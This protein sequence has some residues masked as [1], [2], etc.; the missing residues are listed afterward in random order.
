MNEK[1]DV[2]QQ[3][4]PAAQKARII[5]GCSTDRAASRKEGVTAS[6]CSA[7]VMAHLE[8]C[9]RCGAVGEGPQEGHGDGQRAVAPLLRK[10]AEAWRSLK[11]DLI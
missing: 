1:L 3:S 10:Q 9:E 4:V 7:L 8:Y 5:P 11:V 2:S 6:L